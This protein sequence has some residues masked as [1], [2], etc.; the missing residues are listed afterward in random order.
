MIAENIR[1]L[2]QIIPPSVVL[3]AVSKTKPVEDILEAYGEGQ[4]DFGENRVQEML[5]KY[6][7]LPKDIRWHMIG[8]VQTNKI[9]DF[10]PFVHMVHGIDRLSVLE[11]LEK[12]AAK[13]GRRVDALLQL[14]IAQEE[15]KFG[16]S[17]EEILPL[18]TSSF[19]QQFPHVRLRGF[20]GMAS[21]T[22]DKQQIKREF[23]ALKSLFL[24]AKQQLD[25]T[26]WDTLSMGMSGDYPLALSEGSTLVR[27]GSALFG[28]R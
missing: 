12:E 10:I 14:H 20:M 19:F 22:E 16:F 23:S 8:H 27:I 24:I 18:C 2:H 4:R 11:T 9:K 7:A 21:F 5:S 25:T 17:A 6:H 28:N 13:A 1:T 15:T 26:H 3:V